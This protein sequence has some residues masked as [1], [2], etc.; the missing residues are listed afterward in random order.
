MLL[1]WMPFKKKKTITFLFFE[2]KHYS[3]SFIYKCALSSP[4]ILMFVCTYFLSG[5]LTT[6]HSD[7]KCIM[8]AED[9]VGLPE[10][11][12]DS[13][14][15]QSYAKFY[16]IFTK[17][18]LIWSLSYFA[19]IVLNFLEVSSKLLLNFSSC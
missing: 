15:F 18:N 16:F 13:S 11:I 17:W 4:Y 7:W 9:G 1:L 6:C 8:Q 5:Q 14:S 19:L 3:C 2:L 10:Q 12:L